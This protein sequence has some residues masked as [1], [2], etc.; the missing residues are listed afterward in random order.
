MLPNLTE[1]HRP[2]TL[3]DALALL[4][5]SD[6]RSVPLAGGTELVGRKDKSVEAVVDLQDLGLAYIREEQG[7][8]C[9]GAMTRLQEL[10]DSPVVQGLANGLLSHSAQTTA[11][12]NTRN[13][14]T[15][16]GAVAVAHPEDDVLAALL[17][18]DAEVRLRAPRKKRLA[19]AD[20]IAHK[21]WGLITEIRVPRPAGSV[22]TAYEKVARTPSDRPIV[23]A[24]AL[25]AMRGE[26]CQKARLAL[27]SVATT[28]L[29]VPR[30]EKLLE[31]QK[32]TA[33]L[34][35]QAAQ[36]VMEQ[37]QPPSDFRA[38]AEYRREMCGVLVRRVVEKSA[39]I[40]P[41][42]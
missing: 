5:R 31:K 37:V 29:R 4:R 11:P 6:I 40:S 36:A 17:V 3:D 27:G 32:I 1:Y 22:G 8:V 7:R 21:P 24:T 42:M 28:P 14:A 23:S 25:L 38:S 13:A 10:V 33:Q 41:T 18:L 15:I 2:K 39:R 12:L 20:Y 35:D 26:V 9:I 19:L 30:T 34:I 16:G